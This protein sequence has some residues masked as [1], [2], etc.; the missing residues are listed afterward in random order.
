MIS[1]IT[2]IALREVWRHEALDLT[3]WLEE[4]IDVLEEITGLSISSV[5]REQS[6]GTFSV[7]LVAEDAD[8]NLVVI[9][10]QL[11]RSDHDH[12]GK[13][14]TYLTSLEAKTAIWIVSEPRPEH[15]KAI[16]WLNES[17]SARFYLLKIEAIR[18]GDSP[19]AP[20]LTLITGP[21]QEAQEAGKTKKELVERH[22]IRRRFWADLLSASRGRTKLHAAI[23][24]ST[25]NWIGAGSGIRGVTLNYAV[26]QHDG[27]VELYIDR[28]L[29]TGAE[30][31]RIFDDIHAHKEQIEMEFGEPL[32]WMRLE[33]KRA[34]RIRKVI[35]IGGWRDEEKWQEQHSRMIDAMIRMEKA[36]R[37]YLP[38]LRD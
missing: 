10:N 4:N 18:I 3:R 30:N 22:V 38:K 5:D 29:E 9:E 19:A 26:R 14:I 34:C 12:L 13:I 15:V 17:Q 21:S 37:P 8:G 27:Q 28:D 25:Y 36:I 32:E 11:E 1:K 24:P 35:D 16:A 2:R 20:L 6:A 33:G 7:D 31:E 23:S